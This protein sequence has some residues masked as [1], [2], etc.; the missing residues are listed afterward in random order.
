MPETAQVGFILVEQEALSRS[1]QSLP[2]LWRRGCACTGDSS[3][4]RKPLEQQDRKP[5]RRVRE[6]PL[7]DHARGDFTGG[8]PREE[9]GTVLDA[10]GITPAV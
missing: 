8:C 7:Q 1:R 9:D 10:Q 5:D 2:V 6:L 3:Y 4:R